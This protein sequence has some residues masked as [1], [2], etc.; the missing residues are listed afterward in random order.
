MLSQAIAER[1]AQ[2]RLIA[3]DQ[4]AKY[5]SAGTRMNDCGLGTIREKALPLEDRS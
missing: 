2:A 5:D 3:V 1:A 4:E